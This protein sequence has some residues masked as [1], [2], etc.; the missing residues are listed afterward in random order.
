MKYNR[1]GRIG[2]VTRQ[3]APNV[4][5]ETPQTCSCSKIQV[6]NIPGHLF[7]A[8]NSPGVRRFIAGIYQFLKDEKAF[9]EHGEKWVVRKYT[10]R[11]KRQISYSL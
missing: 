6:M 8:S 2:R 10:Q 4:V 5:P 3:D 7:R 9:P 1:R 11:S